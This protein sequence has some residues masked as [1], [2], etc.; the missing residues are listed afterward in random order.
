MTSS[1]FSAGW[2]PLAVARAAVVAA[3]P[4]RLVPTGGRHA[5]PEAPGLVEM[6]AVEQVGAGRHAETPWSREVFDPQH[7]EDPFEWL[8]FTA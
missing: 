7:D 6:A 2:L 1:A 5:A 3:L 8:G 4:A